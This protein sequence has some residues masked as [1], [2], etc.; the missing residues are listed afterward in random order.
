MIVTDKEY[1][2][3][4]ALVTK[5]DEIIRRQTKNFDHL[6]IIDGDEGIGKS[7]FALGPAYYLAWKTGKSFTVDNVFF[8]LDKMLEFASK[9]ERQVIVWDEAALGGMGMQ[10][11]SKMQQKLIQ[12]LMVARK[13]AHFWF[14]VIPKYHKLNEYIIVDRAI[15]LVHVYS[16]D[17][18]TRGRFVYFGKRDKNRMFY[19]FKKK[20][21]RDYTKYTFRGKFVNTERLID[22]EEYD[23]RKDQAILNIWKDS[24]QMSHKEKQFLLMKYQIASFPE[25]DDA[26]KAR[27][28]GRDRTQ[29]SQWRKL[30][31]KYPQLWDSERSVAGELKY[32]GGRYGKIIER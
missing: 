12:M 20:K 5:L 30:P 11:Q 24:D 6:I 16:H 17:D 14:F 26:T 15:G 7:T 4:N 2:L 29:M 27:L 18:M 8:D 19:K 9:T 3:E 1:Y 32:R 13:K 31:E 22:L 25:L 23:R 28:V 21:I 10:W